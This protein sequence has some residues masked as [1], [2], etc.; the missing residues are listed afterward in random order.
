MATLLNQIWAYTSDYLSVCLCV[1]VCV[2]SI[3]WYI[4]RHNVTLWV[5][6]FWP[7]ILP[8]Q[9]GLVTANELQLWLKW[10]TRSN[11]SSIYFSSIS[12]KIVLHYKKGSTVSSVWKSDW[13]LVTGKNLVPSLVDS[14][15][16][17][18]FTNKWCY[19]KGEHLL[20]SLGFPAILMMCLLEQPS[21][22][23]LFW[24]SFSI[25]ELSPQSLQCADTIRVKS[26]WLCDLIS[27]LEMDICR[28]EA[29]SSLKSTC[30]LLIWL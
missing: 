16:P 6:L 14:R 17:V 19:L 25:S 13:S 2:H 8:E 9:V 1:C 3:P 5:N 4:K 20:Q 12:L 7:A 30:T 15:G 29:T 26:G 18:W 27:S 24:V 22:S 23:K 11:C 10:F 21:K 28:S